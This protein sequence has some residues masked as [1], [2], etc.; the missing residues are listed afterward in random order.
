MM[1]IRFI[2]LFTLLTNVCYSQQQQQKQATQ[3]LSAP[4]LLEGYEFGNFSPFANRGAQYPQP[5]PQ[6]QSLPQKQTLQL[7]KINIRTKIKIDIEYKKSSL[8]ELEK[9]I[10]DRISRIIIN[11][12]HS[13]IYIDINDKTAIISGELSTD[14]DLFLIQGLIALEPGIDKIIDKTVYK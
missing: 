2:I 8:I 4:V 13:K 3:T 7:P 6:I 10:Y 14:E 12:L 5:V 1:V 11:K 9:K